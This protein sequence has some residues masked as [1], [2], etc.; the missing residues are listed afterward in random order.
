MFK[1]KI[2]GMHIIKTDNLQFGYDNQKIIHDLS[3]SVPKGSIYG[4]LGHNGAGKSTTIRLIL[5][6]MKPT[7]GSVEVLGLPFHNNQKTI[8]ARVG[9]LIESPSLYDHLSAFENLRVT[10]T[11]LE[12]G[13][14][15][16]NEVLEIVGLEKEGKKPIRAYSTGMKQRLGL[17]LALLNDPELIILDEP[18]NGLDPQ[19]IVEL[20]GIIQRLNTDLGKTIFL[21]SHILNEIEM[22]CSHVCIIKKGKKL[23]EGTIHDLKATNTVDNGNPVNNGKGVKLHLDT[24][25]LD[26]TK[27]ILNN[28]GILFTHQENLDGLILDL[29]NK[30]K[31]SDLATLLVQNDIGIYEMTIKNQRLEDLFLTINDN[32]K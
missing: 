28:K 2:N 20:R 14:K 30:E 25:N 15:R 4:F 24:N 3:L 26:K 29:Q 31:I 17:G 9:A 5:G 6:L 18:T 12:I 8:Y 13:Q 23:F 21:S 27:L 10:A 16:M 11:Y 19:G 32:E 22:I 7:S 1:T